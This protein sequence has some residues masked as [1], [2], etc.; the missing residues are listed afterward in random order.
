[1]VVSLQMRQRVNWNYNYRYK[2]PGLK[3]SMLQLAKLR[4]FLLSTYNGHW[5]KKYSL[6]T[7]KFCGIKTIMITYFLNVDGLCCLRNL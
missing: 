3:N 1:M 5:E 2:A 4:S 7:G 6:F